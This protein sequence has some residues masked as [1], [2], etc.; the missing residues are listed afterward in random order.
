MKEI[1]FKKT[2]LVIFVILSIKESAVAKKHW[3]REEAYHILKFIREVACP[4]F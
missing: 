4:V 2:L 3:S 1:S